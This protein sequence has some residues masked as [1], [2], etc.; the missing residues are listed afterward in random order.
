MLILKEPFSTL[1]EGKNPFEEVEKISGEV[2]RSVQTRRTIR[3]DVNG[4][5][6]YLKLHHGTE[7]S[8]VVKD[9]ARF[10][11]PVLGADREWA[12]IHR[13]AENGVDTMEGVAYGDTGGNPLRKTSFIITRDLSPVMSAW[14]F[15]KLMSPSVCVKRMILRR[16]AQMV[17]KMHQCGINHR[18]CYLMHFLISMPFDPKNGD[19]E[20][21]KISLIDLHR[22]QLRDE[23]PIRWRNK[24]LIGLLFSA[25]EL[26]IVKRNDIFRFMKEYFQKS[27]KEIWN[28]ERNLIKI[29]IREIARMT[30]HHNK[31]KLS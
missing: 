20:H 1:W 8:D 23:V 29:S 21:L 30:R 4:E 31:H 6:F 12:A 9:F 7:I 2:K 18:D 16:I 25:R 10:R 13:L 24:D 22:A 27:L 19:D 14:A 26:N 3:F 11:L 28:A 15:F 17:R 5:S